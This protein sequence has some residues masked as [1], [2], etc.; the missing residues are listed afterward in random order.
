MIKAIIIEAEAYDNLDS[1]IIFM[2]GFD[3]FA[4]DA[5]DAIDAINL[6]AIGY[7]LKPV[8]ANVVVKTMYNAAQ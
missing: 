8:Q 6:C 4:I 3:N 7:I 2:T 1:K 5:I